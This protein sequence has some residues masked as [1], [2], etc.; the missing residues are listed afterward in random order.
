[1]HAAQTTI[2]ITKA[3]PLKRADALRKRVAVWVAPTRAKRIDLAW[4]LQRLG[5]ENVTSLLVEGGG[6]VNA[7]FLLGRLAHHVAF[8]YAPKIIGG[9]DAQKGVAGEGVAGLDEAIRLT[10]VK[11]RWLGQDLLLLARVAQGEST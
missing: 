1:E 3:A 2:V 9:R 7:S 5:E 10:D 8:F 6:E 11:W 4:V